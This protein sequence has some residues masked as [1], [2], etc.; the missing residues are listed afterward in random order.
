MKDIQP[1]LQALQNALLLKLGDEVDLVFQYGSHVRGA[2]HKYSDVDISYVPVHATTWDSFTVMVDETLFDLYPMHWS[3][4]E[5][6]AEFR[7]V[8]VG[9]LVDYRIVY[10]RNAESLARFQALGERLRALQALSARPEMLKRALEIY[11]ST[12]YDYYL[13]KTQA[14]AGQAAGCIKQAQS[15]FRTVLHCLAVCNQSCADS[16]KLQQILSLPRLPEN[17][18]ETVQRMVDALEPPQVLA[19]TETLLQTTREL[20]LAEQRKVLRSN[21]SIA[22]VF[23]S[24]YPELKRDLQGVMLACERRDLF[25][26]KSSLFS[27]YHEMSRGL[28]QASSGVDYS[29]FNRLAE[30]EQD[31]ASLGFP[32]LLPAFFARDFEDLHQR[33]LAFDQHLRS[34]FGEQSVQTNNFT[35]LDELQAYLSRR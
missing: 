20:L 17:F 14:E 8:S 18:A 13:L 33:C 10:Q 15:I 30:Y 2:T 7:N 1:I 24:A 25:A 27:L 32:A 34:F 16:R 19:A 22:A 31:L 26:L 4:L 11:Q 12:G 21:E 29:K 5:D 23:D 6:M 28:A 9:V 3:T 35:G